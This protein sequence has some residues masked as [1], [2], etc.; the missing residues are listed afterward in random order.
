MPS[1]TEYLLNLHEKNTGHAGV[2][3][4]FSKAHSMDWD[5][6]RDVDWDVEIAKDDPIMAP[7]WSVFGETPTFRSLP[8]E[9]QNHLTRREI[10]RFLNVL[11][12][13]ES[14]AQD[15]C[16]KLALLCDEEDYRNHAVA[17]AMDEARHHAA[18]VRFLQKLDEDDW[19]EI[20][21][22]TSGLFDKL[23][24]SDDITEIVV[25]EQFFLESLAMP[26][27]EKMAAQTRN[28]LLHDIVTLVRRDESRHMGFGVLYVD[29]LVEQMNDDDRTEFAAKWIPR[30]LKAL[31]RGPGPVVE[32]RTTRYLTEVGAKDAAGTAQRMLSEHESVMARERDDATTGRRV[33]QMLASCRRANLLRPELLEPIGLADHPLIEGAQRGA[34]PAE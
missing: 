30:I 15:V 31:E 4:L 20:E 9:V 27:F 21:D 10:V 19:G 25:T 34:L 1:K 24:A 13:G 23:L 5:L 29:R 28:P 7:E 16:A 33:P 17:Q 2:N 6:D 3:S 11:Q 22:F 26:T 32:E 12:V 14:V 18:Y 8:Q